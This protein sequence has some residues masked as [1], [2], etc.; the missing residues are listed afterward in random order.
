[1]YRIGIVGLGHLGKLHATAV[2]HHPELELVSVVDEYP[3]AVESLAAGSG[4]NSFL[5]VSEMIDAELELD[6]C[7][8]S[9]PNATHY[10][11]ATALIGSCRY[12]LIEKPATLKFEQLQDLLER[13]ALTETRIGSALSHRHYDYSLAV[14]EA[15]DQGRIGQPR[16]LRMTMNY[17]WSWGGDWNFWML[18]REAAGSH[19]FHNG[20]HLFDLA[21]WY[22]S[23]TPSIAYTRT[24]KNSHELLQVEDWFAVTVGFTEGAMA[25]CEMNMAFR[26]NGY[27]RHELLIVGSRGVLEMPWYS[28]GQC[29]SPTGTSALEPDW[30]TSIVRQIAELKSA[31][32]GKPTRIP[33]GSE[34]L[35]AMA[36]AEAA[37]KSVD[38]GAAERVTLDRREGH[39]ND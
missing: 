17:P 26:A 2:L 11:V 14:R 23:D 13:G 18:Q 25:I 4:T 38:S 22:L 34:L 16:M 6:A 20:I 39:E 31:L 12:I 1:M 37:V 28:G 7:I 5:S 27:S 24:H 29:L 3:G 32:D 30:R 15:I 19:M 36:T 21:T 9:T 33:E 35:P 8:V 10:A